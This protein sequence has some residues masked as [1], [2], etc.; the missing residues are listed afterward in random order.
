MQNF[1][2]LTQSSPSSLAIERARSRSNSRTR[3]SKRS[4][5]SPPT[6]RR[7]TRDDFPSISK[8][9]VL[10]SCYSESGSLHSISDLDAQHRPE[11][12]HQLRFLYHLGSFLGRVI[13]FSFYLHLA[14]ILSTVICILMFI[15]QQCHNPY[16]LRW[17]SPGGSSG[18][19]GGEPESQA[20]TDSG[21]WIQLSPFSCDSIFTAGHLCVKGEY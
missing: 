15:G 18:N 11:K 5:S 21:K 14:N 10:T 6:S 19:A 1:S 16:W 9:E 12:V 2:H 8:D 13:F 7:N 20:R 4:R 3:S 17:C